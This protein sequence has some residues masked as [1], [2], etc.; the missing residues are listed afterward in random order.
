MSKHLPLFR[1]R[2]KYL[3]YLLAISG[4]TVPHFV[5][6][7]Q[8]PE[9]PLHLQDENIVVTPAGVKPNIMLYIDDSGSMSAT[10]SGSNVGGLSQT[11]RIGVVQ[12]ALNSVLLQHKD[13][14]NWGIETLF[15]LVRPNLTTNI[16]RGLSQAELSTWGLNIN[17]PTWC[18]QYGSNV[19]WSNPSTVQPKDNQ[20]ANFTTD[21]NEVRKRVACLYGNGGSTPVARRY[22]EIT[23]KVVAANNIKNRCQKS[24]V[25]LLSDGDPNGDTNPVLNVRTANFFNN[26]QRTSGN[27]AWGGSWQ[28]PK[29]LTQNVT[30][31]TI[32]F[33]TGLSNSG[34][35]LLRN[36]ATPDS[37]NFYTAVSAADLDNAFNAIF[38]D[39]NS[40][41]PPIEKKVYSSTAPAISSNY[42]DG[43]AAAATL[44]TGSWSSEL[45]FFDVDS[46]GKL[47]T[48]NPK[49]PTF[50]QRKL[51]VS[52]GTNVTLYDSASQSNTWYDIPTVVNSSSQHNRTEWQTGLLKWMARDSTDDA[53]IKSSN[54]NFQL[55]YRTRPLPTATDV[56]NQRS[57]GDIIDNS[58]IAIG[59]ML[60]KRQEFVLTSSNDGLV[61][62]FQASNSTA[63]PYDLKFNYAPTAIQRNSNATNSDYVGKYY[64]YATDKEYGQDKAHPH[65]YLLN[66]G[67]VARTTDKN[68]QGKQIFLASSMGQAGRGAFA[69]NIGGKNRSTGAAIAASNMANSSWN[70]DVKLF[71]TT[72]GA[73][74]TL[75]F[76]IGSPQV[77]RV[78]YQPTST[79]TTKSLGT[80]IRYGTFIGSGYKYSTN[81][82]AT[83]IT[84]TDTPALYI[85]ETLG[86]D[87]GLN[88][89]SNPTPATVN[90]GTLLKRIDAPAGSGGLATPTLVDA[91]FDGIIDYAYAGDYGGNLYRFDLRSPNPN[92]W[93]AVKIF[94]TASNQ[95]ITSA[96]AVY[97]NSD[98]N[99]S[100]T[101]GTGTEIYQEDLENKYQQALYSIIDDTTTSTL[102]TQSDLLEQ[103]LS[104]SATP[105]N[106]RTV[107]TASN[108]P[109]TDRH[110]GWFIKLDPTNGERITLK[111]NMMGNTVLLTTRVFE[112]TVTAA[113]TN[114]DP[115]LEQ[116]QE[117]ATSAYSWIL[118]VSVS[119]GGA[120]PYAKSSTYVN[121]NLGD[122]A[123]YT[124]SANTQLQYA[125]Q[126]ENTLT[127][128]TYV[129]TATAG[130]S[131]TTNGDSGGSGEDPV[132]NSNSSPMKN[133][134]VGQGSK[135]FTFNTE[136]QSSTFDVTGVCTTD[137]TVK[138][139]SWREIF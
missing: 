100:V 79:N 51:L 108:N 22:G 26:D 85:Y 113:P 119:N 30:T 103:T 84:Y 107:R 81:Y 120:I 2:I 136:G 14:A 44:N 41:N 21:Y 56:V 3:S 77:G 132:L 105:V 66:G 6:A 98:T 12:R 33:G 129:D 69:I 7:Q 91:N 47:N 59:D 60:N 99:F 37:S 121:F 110:K 127:S 67:M 34:R 13:K 134:C 35:T 128:L 68:G 138:R 93:N 104:T 96:P 48:S 94:T 62:V 112:K 135:V 19:S 106:G 72:A 65:R 80:D 57:M 8:F 10:V 126:E 9:R 130:S 1:P 97:R 137:V 18:S 87:V 61:Y 42:V 109:I 123:I 25:V 23:N 92:S 45:L 39:I 53:A 82:A 75:G 116:T 11:S 52:D 133:Y 20:R 101:I 58:I 71:E 50:N 49:R 90:K 5:G 89:A 43:L 122:K 40:Q 78:Q 86:Q 115:C 125:G 88:A 24:Y 36:S 76:T 118:Q 73:A 139:L 64:K 28:D 117:S 32:G 29:N 63:N 16:D 15:N 131:V 31:Y 95:P 46:N 83:T 70:Q 38:Q 27:D 124:G 54:A 74:N 111:P 55:D 102:V 114:Q 17:S 4:L